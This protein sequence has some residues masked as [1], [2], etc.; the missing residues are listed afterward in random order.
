MFFR[1]LIAHDAV[2][3]ES[4]VFVA[5]SFHLAHAGA[6]AMYPDSRI[7]WLFPV[8]DEDVPANI[9]GSAEREL[10]EIARSSRD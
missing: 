5:E 10:L 8:E 4:I 2:V 3:S 6:Q 9:R 1:G 7:V